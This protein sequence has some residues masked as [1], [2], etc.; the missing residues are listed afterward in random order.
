MCVK[1]EYIQI[2]T[3][4]CVPIHIHIHVYKA[5]LI[6]AMFIR[7]IYSFVCINYYYS[8]TLIQKES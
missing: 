1:K 3:Y 5:V 8:I 6:Y 4:M 2:C 7:V